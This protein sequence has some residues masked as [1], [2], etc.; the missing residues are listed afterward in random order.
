ML[1]GSKKK[2]ASS[3]ARLSC[4][5]KAMI[6]SIHPTLH[7]ANSSESEKTD[8][9]SVHKNSNDANEHDDNDIEMGNEQGEENE[10]QEAEQTYILRI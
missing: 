4:R 3:G 8:K 5:A 10:F 7:M 6:L 1:E 2:T 9:V